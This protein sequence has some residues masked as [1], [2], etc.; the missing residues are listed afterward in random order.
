[1]GG[2]SFSD[3]VTD[4]LAKTPLM[5]KP[6]IQQGNVVTQ[7]DV[8]KLQPGMSTEQVRFIMGTPLVQDT[9][10]QNRWDYVYTMKK[11]GGA[12]EKK[13][14]ALIFEDDQLVEIKGDYRPD[15]TAEQH[16]PETVVSI[17]DNKAKK[18]FVKGALSTFGF[19][20]DLPQAKKKVEATQEAAGDAVNGASTALPDMDSSLEPKPEAAYSGTEE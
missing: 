16:D 18:G 10:N 17:P 9:F 5:Y 19:G 14:I 3:P 2:G 12:V 15:M 20:D 8:N 13:R 11:G 1:M 7:N 6:D 4:T